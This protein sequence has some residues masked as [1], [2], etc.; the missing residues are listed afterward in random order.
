MP[1][2]SV[3][4]ERTEEILDAFERCV[5]RFGIEG[6]SLER[7]AEEAGLRRSLLRHHV[8]NRDDLVAALAARFLLRS[9]RQ[10]E[11]L[12]AALPAARRAE[13]LVE[14]LFDPAHSDAHLVLVAEALIAAVPQHPD[15]GPKLRAW[16][17]DFVAVVAGELRTARPVA[18]EAACA[19]VAAG[20]VGIYVSVDSLAP[21][22]PMS[23]YRDASKAA[24]LRLLASL[25][26]PS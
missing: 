21:L 4:A 26:K 15:L 13:A 6:S 9:Q 23:G 24:A 14:I 11:Q 17:E 1:R 16:V 12:V 19:E 18:S 20:V 25:E 22:G 8:G 3:K 7:I 2:P 5:A 10:V